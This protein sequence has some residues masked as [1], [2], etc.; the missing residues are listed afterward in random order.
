MKQVPIETLRHML[1][2][3]C[4]TVWDREKPTGEHLWSIPAN[5]ERDFDLLFAAAFDE[6]ETLRAAVVSPARGAQPP[7]EW[8]PRGC[9]A[10]THYWVCPP[11]ADQRCLCGAHMYGAEDALK[12]TP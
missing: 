1:S 4:K 9:T 8:G 2:V 6:L 7:K 11:L 3:L 5:P 12:E 10:E